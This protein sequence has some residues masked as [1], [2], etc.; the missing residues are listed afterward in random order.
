MAP[1]GAGLIIDYTPVPEPAT[2]GLLAT[3]CMLM[4]RRRP[5]TA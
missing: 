4:L 2:L 5:R 1:D 3:G